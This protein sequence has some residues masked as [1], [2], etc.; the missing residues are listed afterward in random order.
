MLTPTRL[1]QILGVVAV[2]LL[3]GCT[4]SDTTPGGQTGSGGG[5]GGTGTGGGS[6]TGGAAS[7]GV[8]G[9][10]G[11]SG[12]GG[13][14]AAT[15]GAGGSSDAGMSSSDGSTTDG[16]GG[17]GRAP[18]MASEG[19]GMAAPQALTMFIRKNVSMKT[20]NQQRVY[21]LYLPSAY[22]P[23]RAYP[24]IFLDHGC[25]GSIPFMESPSMTTVTKGN[26]I[27]VALR[28]YSSQ[29]TGQT[30]GGGCFDT[31]PGSTSLTELAYFDQ[32]LKDIEGV[33]CVDKA[34]VF[35]SGF[36]SGSW[37]T[38]LLG[39]TRAGVIRAQG[40]STGGL[41]SVPKMCAGPIAAM[42]VH[43][44]QDT[45]NSYAGGIIARNRILAI[46]GCSM[47]NSVPYDYDGDP[48]TPSTCMLFQGCMSGYPVVWCPTMN[49]G[50][51]DQVPITT[52]GM[53]RFWSQ[54]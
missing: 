10:T 23:M 29:Q 54:F 1:G 19:C 51:V 39:C 6:G 4:S 3:V 48:A 53:W 33:A 31:G 11:G 18:V 9:G 42:M 25:D 44:M 38:N 26:A 5:A 50:H 28:A 32:V 7:G 47:D 45:M 2:T 15:G 14:V 46:N 43:D 21:D 27:V 40:N 52:T 17:D 8:S 22:D 34:R 13:S 30:Y 49:K 20:N 16:G 24:I 12:T 36:S 41:P 35:M 37:L